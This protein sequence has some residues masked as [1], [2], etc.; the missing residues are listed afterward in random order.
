MSESPFLAYIDE[1]T[2]IIG[3]IKAKN[4][5]RLDGKIKGK[6]KSLSDII[7]GKK[8]EI[9][10][11]IIVGEIVISGR[12]KGK[13]FAKEKVEFEETAR[14]NADVISPVLSIKEG[15]RY[16]GEAR[17]LPKEE[18]SKEIEKEWKS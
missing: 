10:G 17:V 18:V 14:I 3:D 15:A 16:K 9:D 8:G 7:V 1:G 4:P 11:E 13:I 5:L 12:V 2:E 6:I